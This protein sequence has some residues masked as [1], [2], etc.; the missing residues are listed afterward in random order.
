MPSRS[1]VHVDEDKP[2]AEHKWYSYKSRP[3]V[4]QILNLNLGNDT[5]FKLLSNAV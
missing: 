2:R 1:A 4:S 3:N 5:H